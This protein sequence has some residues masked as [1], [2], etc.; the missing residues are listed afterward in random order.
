ML[1]FCRRKASVV[2]IFG[3]GCIIFPGR[4]L[5]IHPPGAAVPEGRSIVWK[6]LFLLLR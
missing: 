3:Y 4:G 2:S 6:I 1:L 5:I